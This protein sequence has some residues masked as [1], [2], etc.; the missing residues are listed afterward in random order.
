MTISYRTMTEGD[1]P[2]II[3]FY[4]DHYNSLGDE[5]TEETVS[6]RIRQVFFCIDSYCMV[7]EQEGSIIGF[8]MGRFQQYYDLMAYD[9][10]EIVIKREYQNKGLGTKFMEELETRVKSHGASMVELMAINDELHDHF[11]GKQKYYKATNLIPMG[12]FLK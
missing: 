2:L 8:A 6:R 11:Y 4:M 5:W 1:I 3:P 7:M 12:K 9:L 10:V